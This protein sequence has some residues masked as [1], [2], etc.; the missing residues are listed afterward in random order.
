MTSR[1]ST[2]VDWRNG[3]MNA[4]ICAIPAYLHRTDSKSI[5]ITS[6]FPTTNKQTSRRK[7]FLSAVSDFSYSTPPKAHFLVSRT[8]PPNSVGIVWGIGYIKSAESQWTFS[9]NKLRY[10]L[11]FDTFINYFSL[12][13]Q[14]N[15]QLINQRSQAWVMCSQ[16]QKLPAFWLNTGCFSNF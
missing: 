7:S 1:C 4:V 8:F 12:F 3:G 14:E 15:K 13:T 2:T 5:W 6:E 11:L 16:L 10:S 9:T